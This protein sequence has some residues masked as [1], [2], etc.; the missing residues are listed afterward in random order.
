MSTFP[1]DKVV[2]KDRNSELSLPL[3]K[4]L[5]LSNPEDD[6]SRGGLY[7]NLREFVCGWGAAFI[8]IAVTFPVSKLIF[9]QLKLFGTP[10]VVCHTLVGAIQTLM[11]VASLSQD[12][13]MLGCVVVFL[14]DLE[15]ETQ[16]W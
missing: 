11:A 9:R 15:S 5:L 7:I 14:S 10:L 13:A 3:S 1:A 8:N 2:V 16:G 12:A 4:K 6:V